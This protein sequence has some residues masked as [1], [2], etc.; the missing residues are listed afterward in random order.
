MRIRLHT[1]WTG[2]NLGDL[3]LDSFPAVLGRGSDCNIS[4]PFGFVSRRHCRFLRRRDQLLVQDLESLNG[5][6]V[7][8]CLAIFPTPLEYG[9][10]LRVGPLSFRVA[11]LAGNAPDALPTVCPGLATSEMTQF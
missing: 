9:D 11:L 1:S 10:E 4:V 2:A 3:Y 6:F 8:G 7:N 5:T